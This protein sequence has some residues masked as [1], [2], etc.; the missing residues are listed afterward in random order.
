MTDQTRWGIDMVQLKNKQKV[1]AEQKEMRA[2]VQDFISNC[3]VFK[4]QK[5]YERMKELKR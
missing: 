3:N 5:M 2:E 1:Y 4:L